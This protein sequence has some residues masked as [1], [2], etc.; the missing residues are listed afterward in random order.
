MQQKPSGI[1]VGRR[2]QSLSFLSPQYLTSWRSSLVRAGSVSTVEP[3]LHH[4]G[5]GMAPD[6]IYATPVASITR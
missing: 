6:T 1:L 5:A 2:P 3:C 4:C